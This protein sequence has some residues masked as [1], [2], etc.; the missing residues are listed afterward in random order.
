M[1]CHIVTHQHLPEVHLCFHPRRLAAFTTVQIL[2]IGDFRLHCLRHNHQHLA[3]G[4]AP[5]LRLLHFMSPSLD[6]MSPSGTSSHTASSCCQS[7]HAPERCLGQTLASSE[8]LAPTLI[9]LTTLGL[10]VPAPTDAAFDLAKSTGTVEFHFA[11]VS[12]LIFDLGTTSYEGMLRSALLLCY[13][14]G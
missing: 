13:T 10:L 5:F 1:V 2:C 3:C 11:R 8:P 14:H 7:Y 12:S 4:V 6:S 9:V